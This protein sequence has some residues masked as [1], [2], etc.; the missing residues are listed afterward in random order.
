MSQAI[1]KKPWPGIVAFTVAFFSQ[2]LGHSAYMAVHEA[3]EA[4]QYW[5]AFGIGAIG[6]WIVWQGIDRPEGPA[7]WLGL[8]GGLLIWVGWF[9]FSFSGFAKLYAVEGF[10][11]D[12][13]YTTTPGSNMLQATMPLMVGL[14]F[15]YGMFNRNTKCNFMRWFHRNLRFSPGMPVRNNQRNFA[16]IVALEIIFV[17]WFCYLFWLYTF[18]LGVDSPLVAGI[19]LVWSAWAI[20]LLWKLVKIPRVAHAVRYGIPV[21]GIFWATFEMPSYFGAYDEIWLKPFEYPVTTLAV[22]AVFAGCFVYIAR[23]D[24]P[25]IGSHAA[26]A[27]A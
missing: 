9:E 22:L 26:T 18:F 5:I 21:G 25:G 14:F 12:D 19:Y 13:L 2:W 16:R 3:F 8:L 27:S 6:C 24:R 23:H 15:I 4:Y 20:Y 17:I 11:V 7:T 10:R 1:Y